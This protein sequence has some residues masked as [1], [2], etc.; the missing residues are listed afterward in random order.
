MS[1]FAFGLAG[2]S[3]AGLPI[4]LGFVA[5]W[6]LLELAWGL[7]AWWV[8]GVL[9]VGGLLTA[10]YVFKVL[11]L[12]VTGQVRP[13]AISTVSRVRSWSALGLASAAIGL[14]WGGCCV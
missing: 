4:S 13:Q 10:G 9:L 5:K 6:S 7:Q 1:T 3:L 14:G 2:V 12:A 8:M 11:N